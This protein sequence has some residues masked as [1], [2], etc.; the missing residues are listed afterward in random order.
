VELATSKKNNFMD[1]FDKF[2]EQFENHLSKDSSNKRRHSVS[3][4]S[5]KNQ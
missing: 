1:E 5:K 2:E 4:E 3:H